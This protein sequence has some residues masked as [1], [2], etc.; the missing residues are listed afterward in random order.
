MTSKSFKVTRS[1]EEWRAL[2]TPEQYDVLRRHGT[3]RP[4]SCALNHEKRA[5]RVLLRRLR[6][7]TV[8]FGRKIRERHRLAELF[9]S[10]RR[11]R[12]RPAATPAISWSAPRSIAASAAAISAMSSTTARRPPISA[13]ASMA[14]RWTSSPD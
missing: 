7:G 5:R 6:P 4:G 14:S 10:A 3:E 12:S 1:D 2:L 11:A 13:I 8:P 9:R